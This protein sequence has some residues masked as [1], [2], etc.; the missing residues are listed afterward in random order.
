MVQH[1]DRESLAQARIRRSETSSQYIGGHR[2]REWPCPWESASNTEGT[3]VLPLARSQ[4]RRGGAS[5]GASL[6][7]VSVPGGG[8]TILSSASALIVSSESNIQMASPCS[9]P[10]A[11]GFIHYPVSLCG[12]EWAVSRRRSAFRHGKAANVR[13]TRSLLLREEE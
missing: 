1:R 12:R 9:A 2:A 8:P 4:A 10:S 3:D 5:S 11:Y 6:P 7:S 13:K